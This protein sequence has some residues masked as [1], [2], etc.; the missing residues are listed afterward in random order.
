M[1][2]IIILFFFGLFPA[3]LI[4][5]H[6]FAFWSE[7]GVEG[8]AAGDLE[9]AFDIN[10]RFDEDG[11]QTFFPQ[12]GLSYKLNKWF[13]PSI[14]Y[15]F[16]VEKNKVGNYKSSSRI[17]FNGLFDKTINK[18]VKLTARLRYQFVPQI[19][20]TNS[21]DPDFDQA[22]RLKPK[23]KWDINDFKL[24]PEISTEFFYNPTY[25]PKGRQFTKLRYA[26][27]VSLD[28]NNPHSVSLLYRL[29]HSLRSAKSDLKH[30]VSLSYS[31][32]L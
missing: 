8:E 32:K 1:K 7:A 2:G 28:T 3:C 18:R 10:A 27:G 20:V 23:I 21:Y 4:G 31:Y 15:R 12:P 14:E 25:G 24:S 29:D 11:L 19:N 13:R 26:G 30:I 17:N 5:Q 16:L 6:D 22:I 9:W